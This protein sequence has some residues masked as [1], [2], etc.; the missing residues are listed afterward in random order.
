M[1]QMPIRFFLFSTDRYIEMDQPPQPHDC[2]Q[3]Q[4]ISVITG[5]AQITTTVSHSAHAVIQ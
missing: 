5:G 3:L 1:L 4:L 2:I